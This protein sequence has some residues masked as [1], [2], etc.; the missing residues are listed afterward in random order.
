MMGNKISLISKFLS[1]VLVIQ[2]ASCGVFKE[3]CETSCDSPNRYAIYEKIPEKDERDLMG[4][5]FS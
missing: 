5:I 1:L 2:F 3:K 4:K